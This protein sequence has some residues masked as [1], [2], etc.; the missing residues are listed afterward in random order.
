M[1][2]C[3]WPMEL[4]QRCI[5]NL[6]MSLS[7]LLFS[8]F[9]KINWSL[10]ELYMNIFTGDKK[11]ISI[12]KSI[13]SSHHDLTPSLIALHGL[14]GYSSVPVMFGIGKLKTLKAGSKIPLRYVRD[15]DANLED[16]VREGKQ[17]VAKCYG[18]NQLSLSENRYTKWK[19][20]TVDNNNVQK[21]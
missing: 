16:V 4:S 10:T 6:R 21:V 9:K 12:N 13:A 18:Q 8:N 19:N 14:S 15:V 5:V 17:F 2:L 3:W 11:L 7:V 20:K 1:L